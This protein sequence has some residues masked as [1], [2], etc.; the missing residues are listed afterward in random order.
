MKSTN[1]R[2]YFGSM[3][4]HLLLCYWHELLLWSTTVGRSLQK[5][6]EMHRSIQQLSFGLW[7]CCLMLTACLLAWIPINQEGKES[8]SFAHA[9]HLEYA[10]Y[11]FASKCGCLVKGTKSFLHP[12]L[13]C[14]IKKPGMHIGNNLAPKSL[15]SNI[16]S[17]DIPLIKCGFWTLIKSSIEAEMIEEIWNTCIHA[18]HSK[19]KLCL[20]K[21]NLNV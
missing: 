17:S 2:T 6:T 1:T 8:T 7:Y 11:K 21:R 15:R 9:N 3:S 18:D 4:R 10:D 5:F 19:R 16:D 13:F 12:Q 14:L 20:Q